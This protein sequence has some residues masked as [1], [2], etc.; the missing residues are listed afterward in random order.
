MKK[1]SVIILCIASAA[2][3]GEEDV[4]KS[5]ART[6]EV[7]GTYCVFTIPANIVVQSRGVDR[8]SF[9][10]GNVKK[11]SFFTVEA[12]SPKLITSPEI[13]KQMVK[14]S[15]MMMEGVMSK[16][17]T[18][19]VKKSQ[20]EITLGIFEG[21]EYLLNI[22]SQKEGSLYMHYFALW[23]GE[24][25]WNGNLIAHSPETIS[26]VYSILKTAKRIAN[27]AIDSDKK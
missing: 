8:Y 11:P 22:T 26:E 10:M 21:V 27:K 17:T 18:T 20:K 16:D 24:R 7:K 19:T 3:Y 9:R 1:L 12:T 25:A 15:V 23:D 5:T 13:I 6:Q 14:S 2:A 4:K